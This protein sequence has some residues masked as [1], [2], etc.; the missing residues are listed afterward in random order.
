[1]NEVSGNS[2]NVDPNTKTILY[3]EDDDSYSL[4][5][6]CALKQGGFKETLRHVWNGAEAIAYIKGEGKYADR[7]QF[8]FP[9]VVLA[10]LK[11]PCVS[12][13]DLLH[14][15]RRESTSPHLPVV[16]LTNSDEMKDVR[17]AYEM[18]ANSFLLKPINV[19]DLRETLTAL[20]HFWLRC[21]ILEGQPRR[22]K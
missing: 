5:L 1:M 13:F 16:V 10:D 2:L 12:G 21:N 3:A 14:W 7:T 19:E 9:S 6:E 17:R 8:P 18:G 15:I 20:D 11:M 22:R 4:L